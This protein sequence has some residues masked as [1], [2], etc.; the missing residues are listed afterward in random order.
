MHHF[1]SLY[2]SMDMSCFPGKHWYMHCDEQWATHR[3]NRLPVSIVYLYTVTGSALSDSL[4]LLI[5]IVTGNWPWQSAIGL[6]SSKP[7]QKATVPLWLQQHFI[8]SQLSL[9]QNP[10]FGECTLIVYQIA[11]WSRSVAQANTERSPCQLTVQCHAPAKSVQL[12]SGKPF[13]WRSSYF[14]CSSSLSV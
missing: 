9:R 1:L 4:P 14:I 10:R 13:Q 2:N 7:N 11:M 3:G 5:D 6:A 12:T 8:S